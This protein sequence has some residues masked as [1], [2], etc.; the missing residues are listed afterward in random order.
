MSHMMSC[1][2]SSDWSADLNQEVLALIGHVM[3][4]HMRSCDL[5]SDWSVWK[6]KEENIDLI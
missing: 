4:S 2:R 6:T 5:S 3:M 1:D